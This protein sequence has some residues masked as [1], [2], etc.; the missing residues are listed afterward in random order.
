MM[1]WNREAAMLGIPDL[2]EEGFKHVGDGKI[3]PQGG[4]GGGGGGHTTSTGTQYTSAV[5]EWLKGEQKEIVA[6]GLALAEQPYQPY[7]GERTSQFTPLQR[8]AFGSAENQQVAGQLGMATGLTGLTAMQS[9][10]NP[11]TASSFMNPFLE[12]ALA[13]QLA[14]AAR[15]SAIQGTQQQAEATQRGA[16]GGSRDAIMRAEREKNLLAEQSGII[17]RGYAQAFES[18]QDQ[19][20]REQQ[21]RLAAAGQLGQLGQQQFGQEMDIMGRQREFGDLQQQ[22][23]QRILDQQYADFQAQRDFPYQQIGFASDLIQGRGGSTRTMYQQPGPSGLQTIAGLGT[24]AAGLGGLMAKGGEVQHYADGGITRLLGDQELEQTA[25]NPAQGPMMQMAAQDQM[26][27]NAALRA[28]APQGL[29]GMQPET[30]GTAEAVL[31]QKMVEALNRGDRRLAEELAAALEEIKVQQEV[32]GIAGM[33]PEQM[34]EGIPEGGIMQ[35]AMGGEVQTFQAGGTPRSP[36]RPRWEEELERLQAPPEESSALAQALKRGFLYSSDVEKMREEGRLPA[37]ASP[38]ASKAPTGIAQ[39]APAA[40]TADDRRRLTNPAYRPPQAKKDDGK[41]DAP[42]AAPADGGVMGAPGIDFFRQQMAA[43]GF[44]PVAARKNQ[45]AGLAALQTARRGAAEG[46]EA[47][48]EKEIAERGVLGEEREARAKEGLAALEGKKGEAKSMALFRAGL[49]IWTAD[50]RQGPLAAIGAGAIEG[51]DAY[52]GDLKDLEKQRENLLD[53][54]DTLDDLRRQERMAD[55]KE[56]RA[57]RQRIRE[58]EV[59]GAKDA[60]QLSKDFDVDIPQKMA[61]D[62]F[63]AWGNEFTASKNRQALVDRNVGTAEDK[64]ITAAENAFQRDPEAAALRKQLENPLVTMDPAAQQRAIN[65]LREIQASKYKQFGITMSEPAGG[66]D[67][68]GF[69]V[70]GVKQ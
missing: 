35:M 24:A 21:A 39:V 41:T 5:P 67:M 40:A 50:P 65:R 12:Q 56:R 30:A 22:Q 13:P 59:E 25:Q 26:A 70:V 57:I 44:D 16:F 32:G 69:R 62:V 54:L 23:I 10:R 42:P 1:R 33:M 60:M 8:Q 27:E 11:G 63:R 9:F 48:L 55:G 58:V 17:G 29:P 37:P 53:K 6:R 36:Y 43:A 45:E 20:N 66:A 61:G 7:G 64:K 28:A 34:A 19:F 47:D 14:G 49:A 68:T 31:T 3:K 2:P 46:A 18:A 52:K 51:L 4:S 38:K 15:Q